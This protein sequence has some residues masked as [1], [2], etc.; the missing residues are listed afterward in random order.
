MAESRKFGEFVKSLTQPEDQTGPKEPESAEDAADGMQKDLER[1]FLPRRLARLEQERE[2][3]LHMLERL[4][5]KRER[6]GRPATRAAGPDIA[7]GAIARIK[8]IYPGI[9][10]ED[11]CKRLDTTR[12]GVRLPKRFKELG[13]STWH[14][15]WSDKRYRNRVK[16]E[17]SSVSA[18]KRKDD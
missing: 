1:Y 4:E 12:G 6:H 10:I 9:S 17:I 16:R 13:F 14:G 7:D 5:K 8:R 18:A 3:L 11:I 2:K 15:I